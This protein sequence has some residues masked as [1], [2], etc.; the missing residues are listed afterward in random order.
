MCRSKAE[1]G[2]RCEG[3]T[4]NAYARKAPIK[5]KSCEMCHGDYYP[6]GNAQLY[7]CKR[8]KD[9]HQNRQDRQFRA[10]VKYI[11]EH[12]REFTPGIRE[13]MKTSPKILDTFS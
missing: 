7:C 10:V 11:K 5:S 6:K 4:S 1:G 12:M 3:H 13:Y 9:E 2:Q 8:C